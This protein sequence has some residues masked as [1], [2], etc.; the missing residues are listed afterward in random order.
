MLD[1]ESKNQELGN[2]FCEEIEAKFKKTKQISWP[3]TGHYFEKSIESYLPERC[4]RLIN[5][6]VTREKDINPHREKLYWLVLSFAQDL[7]HAVTGGKWKLPKHIL[8]WSTLHPLY[9]CKLL[10][11]ILNRLG[12]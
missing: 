3:M 12:H 9:R 7:C 8:L 5:I 2:E 10:N 11:C 6:M 1:Q 4:L